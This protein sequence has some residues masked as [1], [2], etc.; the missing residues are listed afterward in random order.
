[1]PILSTMKVFFSLMLFF[2]VSVIFA[3]P[4]DRGY[5]LAPGVNAS[6]E[7][8]D[9]AFINARYRVIE[10]SITYLGT[11]YRY[12]GLNSSGLDCSGFIYLSF[13][14][15]LGVS[16]PRS[17]SALFSWAVRTSLE[18][19]QPGDLLFFRTSNTNNI[20]HVGLYLGNRIFIHAASHGPRTGVIYSSLN[21][22]YWANC[23]AGVG[24]VFP[25]TSPFTVLAN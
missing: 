3:A 13:R 21:E 8:R 10:A 1:M 20:T 14:D 19:A 2:C 17:S 5:P 9:N 4:L 15:A 18:R 11:P 25:E 24:R 16:L 22:Q 12:G 7:E 23:Y 6:H